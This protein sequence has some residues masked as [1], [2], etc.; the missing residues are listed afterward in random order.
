LVV[1]D[2]EI[3]ETGKHNELIAKQGL[4][5]ELV[6]SQVF[7]DIDEGGRLNYFIKNQK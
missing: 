4:Y 5:Y 7:T 1:K 3:V 6:N 2:G